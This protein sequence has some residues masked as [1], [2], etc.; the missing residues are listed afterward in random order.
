MEELLEFAARH[1]VLSL[2]FVG[3]LGALVVT[4]M[5][6]FGR[7]FKQVS[8]TE[9]TRLIN[10]EDARVLDVSG[11]SEFE[12]GH[13]IDARNI[14]A[15]QLATREKDLNKLRKRPLVV[16]C[17]NG[18]QSLKACGQLGKMGFE[19][20]YWLKGGYGAWR[21]ENLPVMRGRK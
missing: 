21:G 4:E 14:P 18:Q 17:R 10:R 16:Y 5:G 12:A 11:E 13:I 8:P 20:L 9:A 19:N 7:R 2:A 6:H 15:G 3:L 1:W